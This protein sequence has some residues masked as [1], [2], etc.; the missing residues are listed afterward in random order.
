MEKRLAGLSL[1]MALIALGVSLF[2][3]ATPPEPS[4]QSEV[5]PASNA[6]MAPQ[7]PPELLARVEVLESRLQQLV[8]ETELMQS[9]AVR[10]GDEA[11]APLTLDA[12]IPEDAGAV[13]QELAALKRSQ[14][15]LA[16]DLEQLGVFEHF[17]RRAEH[18]D[19]VYT[20]A[21]NPELDPKH[22]A[23][24]FRELRK[25][26]QFD[27][28]VRDA[29]VATLKVAEEELPKFRVHTV[30][31]LAGMRDDPEVQRWFSHLAEN[32]PDEK[33]RRVA[34]HVMDRGNK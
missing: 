5:V 9:R 20:V 1:L 31:T 24:A 34:G 10:D 28:K 13:A 22:R 2:H 6:S 4:I 8:A 14:Q 3:R 11:P 21:L 32:D 7:V 12:P 30:E 33:V 17:E 23:K 19:E 16:G 25:T 15:K 29:M 27:D 18:L 26:G